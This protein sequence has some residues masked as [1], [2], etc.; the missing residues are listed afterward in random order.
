MISRQRQMCLCELIYTQFNNSTNILF[1]LFNLVRRTLASLCRKFGFAPYSAH[2]PQFAWFLSQSEFSNIQ[3]CLI[4]LFHLFFYLFVA[5]VQMLLFPVA[6]ILDL[7]TVNSVS[8]YFPPTVSQQ[9]HS[10]GC[11]T[12]QRAGALFLFFTPTST[13]LLQKKWFIFFQRKNLS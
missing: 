5:V 10:V 12:S 4:F 1:K 11:W 9:L 3:K 6:K 7:Y 13:D 8:E 2:G